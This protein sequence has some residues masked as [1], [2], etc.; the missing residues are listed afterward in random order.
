[1]IDSTNAPAVTH[2]VFTPP[3]VAIIRPPMPGPTM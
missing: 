2:M 3:S 1:M